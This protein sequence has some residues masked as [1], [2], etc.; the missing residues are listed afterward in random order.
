MK[1]L[2]TYL[3]IKIRDFNFVKYKEIY[4]YLILKMNTDEID[5][6]N[7]EN[8]IDNIFQIIHDKDEDKDVRIAA[9]NNLGNIIWLDC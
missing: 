9:I 3:F 6:I 1:E 2:Q 4:I 5:L 8:V 7:A